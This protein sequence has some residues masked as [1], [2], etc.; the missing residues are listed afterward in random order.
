[1]NAIHNANVVHDVKPVRGTRARRRRRTSEAIVETALSILTAEGFDALTMKRLADEMGYAI[2]AF[3]RYF[4][5][6]D[7]LLLA[8]QRKV[9]EE[10]AADVRA[11]AAAAGRDDALSAEGRA[12][13]PLLAAARSY[14]TLARRRP[15]HSALLARWLGDPGPM[16][17]TEAA[18]PMVAGLIDLFG[19]V[20]G[21]FEEAAASGAL[22]PGDPQR[23]AFALWCALQG[24]LQVKKLDRFGVAA[25]DNEALVGELVR[26]LFVGWGAD[27][28]GFATAWERA[29]ALE[30]E[31]E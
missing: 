30:R 16:V 28:D 27:P 18:A 23:R 19:V 5:S 24:A 8:V 29:A 21:R 4:P 25:F 9:L 1:V 11:S 6:K 22:R 7:A 10:L 2:G 15:V 14:V 13:L 20:P 3:Y 31:G 12:L 17:A 26:A